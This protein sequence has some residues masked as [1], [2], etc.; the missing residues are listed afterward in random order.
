MIEHLRHGDIDKA[1]WDRLL[2][3]CP[4]RLWYARSQVLDAAS[5]G[6]EALV[7]RPS[8]A[9]MPLTVKRKWGIR[10]LHQ[11]FM[12]Q[13][14]GV[15][16]PR[17]DEAMTAAFLAAIP[18]DIRYWDIQLNEAQT[19]PAVPG[20]AFTP[21]TNMVVDLR[22]GVEAVRSGYGQSHRR[23]LRKWTGAEGMESLDEATFIRF[24]R[25]APQVKGWNMDAGR[26]AVFEALVHV[27]MGS[28]VGRAMGLHGDGGMLAAGLFV[29][30]AGRTTFLKGL[31]LAEGRPVFAMHR[32]MDHMISEACATSDR[33][34]MAGGN[35]ADLRRFYAGFG[36]R[37]VLYL[38]A[39]ANRLPQPLRWYKQRNDGA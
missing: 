28:G 5:P 13:Q 4:N 15:F 7:D 14:A 19:G 26:W 10:Y 23:G 9:I 3:A 11:P 24:I 8:G 21:R 1:G 38:R 17:V 16:A 36:A 12:L 35:D 33:F 32:L 2:D 20:V 27:A 30:W 6:W 18:P 34:D 39:V 29:S 31:S 25:E 22:E 37:P